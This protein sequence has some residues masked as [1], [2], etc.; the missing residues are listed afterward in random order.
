MKHQ[1]LRLISGKPFLEYR[2]SFHHYPTLGVHF[3]SI[4]DADPRVKKWSDLFI[5]IVEEPR[6]ILDVASWLLAES[7]DLLMIL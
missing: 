4:N 5:Y 1:M 3:L 6:S 2:P 7:K